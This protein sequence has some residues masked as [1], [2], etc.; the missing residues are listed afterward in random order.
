MFLFFFIKL[1]LMIF[2]LFLQVDFFNVLKILPIILPVLLFIA[3]FTLLE[4]KVLGAM[5]RRRGP[6]VVGIFGLLQAIADGLKLL[7]KETVVPSLANKFIFLLAPAITFVFSLLSWAVVPFQFGVVMVDSHVGVLIIFALSSLGVYS[8]IMSGWSS[9]SKYAFLGALRSAAQ[10]ISY[11]VS[12]AL[13]AMPVLL[14]AGSANLTTIVLMQ[15]DVFFFVPLVPSFILFFISLLAETN[16]VPFDLPEAESELVSGY[17]VEY[18][19]VVFVFFFLAEYAN[20][21]LMCSFLVML[22][23]GGWLPFLSFLP[24]YWLPLWFWFVCK[25]LFFVFCFIWVRANLP[26]YRYD[27]LMSIVGRSSFLWL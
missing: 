5:Q 1:F 16:R 24:F 7:A 6:N 20:I 8:L 13:L 2:L 14:I 9:N 15:S 4:R 27:Q 23:F 18:S 19:S 25:V 11:E 22:F 17:N 12:M 21:I 10:L 3:F 26:R